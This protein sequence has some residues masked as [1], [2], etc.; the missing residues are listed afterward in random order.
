MPDP[1]TTT[2]PQ[3]GVT[4]MARVA[5]TMDAAA[6]TC[7]RAQRPRDRSARRTPSR[8]TCT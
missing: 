2:A 7:G 4:V 8:R 1:I 3:D 6:G 5:E